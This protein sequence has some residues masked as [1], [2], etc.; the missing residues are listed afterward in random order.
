LLAGE[1][2]GEP[3]LTA[4]GTVAE[5]STS[6]IRLLKAS[7]VIYNGPLP[8]RRVVVRCDECTVAKIVWETKDAPKDATEYT[9]LQYLQEHKPKFPAP[10]PLGHLSMGDVSIFFVSYLPG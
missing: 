5:C 7:Q 6:V 9:T 4:F 3:K 10:K 8:S 2:L 1:S